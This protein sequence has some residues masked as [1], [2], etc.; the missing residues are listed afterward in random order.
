MRG[1]RKTNIEGDCLKR[2]AWK[3]CK[4][5]GGGLA[6][7]REI[8]FLRGCDTPMHTMYVFIKD[9]IEKRTVTGTCIFSF[10]LV[11]LKNKTIFSTYYIH[12]L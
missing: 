7:K 4:F 6:R 3:V 5:K 9:I 10:K 1:L 8:V 2:R 12:F 11:N